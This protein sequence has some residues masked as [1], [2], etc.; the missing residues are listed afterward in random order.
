MTDIVACSS[1]N[2]TKASSCTQGQTFLDS[3]GCCQ[4]CTVCPP[5]TS[6]ES[7]CNT[8]HDTHCV[9]RSCTD[10]NT[11]FMDNDGVCV[12]DCQRCSYDCNIE[13]NRCICDPDICYEDTTFCQKPCLPTTTDVLRPNI[14]INPRN[15]TTLPTWG[16][17]VIAVVAVLGIIA[18][19]AVFLLLGVCTRKRET[20]VDSEASESS[21]NILVTSSGVSR[22]TNSTYLAGYPNHSLIDLLRQSN[23]L[24]NS[25]SN[26]R[27]SPK[28]ARAS[29]YLMKGVTE[30]HLDTKSPAHCLLSNHSSPLPLRTLQ[31][32]IDG[33]SKSSMV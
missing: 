7:A 23:P 2:V 25:L 32:N 17:G 31:V 11:I 19:S 9:E 30:Y 27:S 18:F 29:P 26:I 21:S 10:P 5:G 20:E 8:T 1:C 22:G 6:T 24:H 4:R 3:S 15:P 14:S 33:H 13:Q 28:S 12:I 16:I